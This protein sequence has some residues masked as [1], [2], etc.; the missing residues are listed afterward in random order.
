MGSLLRP[1]EAGGIQQGVVGIGSQIPGSRSAGGAYRSGFRSRCEISRARECAVHSLFSGADFAISV[2]ARALPRGGV[3][4][5]AA[6]L[7]DLWQQGSR[8]KIE[9]DALAG[10]EQALAGSAGSFNR[11]ETTGC[12]RTGRLFRAAENLAG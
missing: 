4:R 12:Q 9:Q 5:T 3:L 6:S 10:R 8:R 11:R 7:L 2:S 1:S